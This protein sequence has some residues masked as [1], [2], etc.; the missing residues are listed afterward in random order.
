MTYFRL[1]YDYNLFNRFNKKLSNQYVDSFL[2]KRK[3][4]KLTYELNL[5]S[6][7]K[8]Y[9]VMSMTQSESTNVSKKFYRRFKSNHS[10]SIDIDQQN[11]N[12]ELNFRYEIKQIVKRRQR[13]FDK[14][15]M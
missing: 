7:F 10:K 5:S 14:I 13:I 12:V 2:M 3:I 9:F 8:M 4:D 1:H 6:N 15:K 11:K